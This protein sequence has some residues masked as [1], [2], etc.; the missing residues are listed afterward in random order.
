MFIML[1]CGG[2][3]LVIGLVAGAFALGHA[4][5]RAKS[6][7]NFL[8]GYRLH[9]GGYL[10]WKSNKLYSTIQ[11]TYRG[12]PIGNPVEHMFRSN[13]HVNEEVVQAAVAAAAAH[14]LGS[15]VPLQVWKQL[16]DKRR[17]GSL[18]PGNRAGA[19]DVTAHTEE[20]ARNRRA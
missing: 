19:D 15:P 3:V 18:S 6:D 1:A 8:A 16:R 17:S 20:P 4:Q 7:L 10:L 13:V 12:V 2:A 5:A 14:A 11:Y 9:E